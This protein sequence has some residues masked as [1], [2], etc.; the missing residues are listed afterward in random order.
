MAEAVIG[1]TNP[2]A[3][4]GGVD[5]EPIEQARLFAPVAFQEQRRAV[6]EDDFTAVALRHPM[7]RAAVAQFRWTG[8]WYTAVVVVERRDGLAVDEA[9]EQELLAWFE[10]FRLAGG[11][12]AVR[13]PA[14][15]GLDID[16]EVTAQG[17]PAGVGRAGAGGGVRTR[18]LLRAGR[19]RPRPAAV[20]QPPR[21]PGHGAC[22]VS[23][24]P[25]SCAS[26]VP[27]GR[28]RASSTS[29]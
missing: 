1:V 4:R 19:L 9:F 23:P 3:A 11:D 20:P 2:V 10:P 6:V 16:V 25:R 14:V 28:P 7:V 12:I 18:R 17:L 22:P 21:G 8:S 5:P 15:V 13:G 27:L 24:P 26:S 29:A